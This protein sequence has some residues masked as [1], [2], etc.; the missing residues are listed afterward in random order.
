MHLAG[1]TV[2]DFLPARLIGVPRH[3]RLAGA[4]EYDKIANVIEHMVN[5]KLG[6]VDNRSFYRA[7]EG[8]RRGEAINVATLMRTLLI[9]RWLRHL[10]D[11]N[12]LRPLT[13]TKLR[14]QHR[15]AQAAVKLTN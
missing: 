5:A 15:E 7:L 1:N 11:W 6:I 2:R 13:F 9:E 3:K 8:A 4:R 10:A 14:P 12:F